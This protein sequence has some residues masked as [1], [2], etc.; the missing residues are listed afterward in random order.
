MEEEESSSLN[1]EERKEG[2]KRKE[3]KKQRGLCFDQEKKYENVASLL[4]SDPHFY[5]EKCFF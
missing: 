5:F 1:E 4:L 2:E 3:E